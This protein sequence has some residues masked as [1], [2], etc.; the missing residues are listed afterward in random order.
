LPNTTG[1]TAMIKRN[2]VRGELAN[3]VALRNQKAEHQGHHW[4]CD[5]T[6]WRRQASTLPSAKERGLRFEFHPGGVHLQVVDSTLRHAGN[7]SLSDQ[8]LQVAGVLCGMT[9]DRH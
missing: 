3:L 5:P 8:A 9:D 7:S 4:L 6:I 1:K 2:D